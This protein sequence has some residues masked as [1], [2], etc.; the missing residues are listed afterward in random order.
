MLVFKAPYKYCKYLHELQ[1][2]SLLVLKL[3]KYNTLLQVLI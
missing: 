3:I 1:I 2:N